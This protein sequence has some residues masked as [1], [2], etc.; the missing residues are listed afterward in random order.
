MSVDLNA[1]TWGVTSVGSVADGTRVQTMEDVMDGKVRIVIGS[2]ITALGIA[3]FV[4]GATSFFSCQAPVS[5]EAT[6]SVEGRILGTDGL[7]VA[8]IKGRLQKTDLDTLDVDW[9]VGSIVNA[10]ATAFKETTT[11]TNGTF[12][13][14]FGGAEANAKN[15][16]WAA[17]FVVY[18]IAP[19]DTENHLAMAT[20][21]FQFS[22]Q[23]LQRALPDMRFW[24]LDDKS[25][26]VTEDSVT[27]AW[28]DSD[29]L[30][31]GG[32]YILEV[33]GTAWAAEVEGTAYTLPLSA[34]E[35]CQTAVKD[36][37]SEC[38]TR[39]EHRVHLISLADGI[40]YRTGWHKFTASNPV[41][42][43][44]W[45][46]GVGNI[47]GKTCSDKVLYDL[48]DGKYSGD[49]AIQVLGGDN[50]DGISADDFKCLVI[51]L[52]SEQELNEVYLHNGA[53]V[54]HKKAVIGL[55]GAVAAEPTE[56]DWTKLGEWKGDQNRFWVHNSRFE[57]AGAKARWLKV[58]FTD[59]N[60]NTTWAWLGE[61]AVYAK[62]PALQ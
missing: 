46:R 39:K 56:A 30:P 25:I 13:F 40:R 32:K 1:A 31:E 33:E 7:P 45:Y 15:Q 61:I 20:D 43:G 16:A 55:L 4:F 54:D 57:L 3:A 29:Q 9:L 28:D 18:V 8:N 19:A 42:M 21:S 14:E 41:G 17:Y 47:S 23:N 58:Q 6:V 60:P 62:L 52:G 10:D 36:A 38:Q 5:D 50:A 26:S 44:L 11:D 12:R 49:N 48:N 34:L 22:N 59:Q 24:D 2:A 37:A 51:D 27:F 53:I 35:P